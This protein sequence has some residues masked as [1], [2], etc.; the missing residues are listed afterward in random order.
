MEIERTL[1]RGMKYGRDGPVSILPVSVFMA[2]PTGPVGWYSG[3]WNTG[4]RGRGRDDVVSSRRVLQC[5]TIEVLVQLLQFQLDV[6]HGSVDPGTPILHLA[7]GFL[8]DDVACLLHRLQ[9]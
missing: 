6:V 4:S 7:N 8:Q 1:D 9:I 3:G 5:G 2:V